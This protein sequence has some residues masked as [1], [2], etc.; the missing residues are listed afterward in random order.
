MDKHQKFVE[1]MEKADVE[2][3]EEYLG[4]FFYSGPAVRTR[5]ISKGR[6]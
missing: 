4:R 6:C 3:D 5:G 2:V 1:D